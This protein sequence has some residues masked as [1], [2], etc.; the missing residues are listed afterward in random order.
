MFV[1]AWI[2]AMAMGGKKI[3]RLTALNVLEKVARSRRK[4]LSEK[5]QTKPINATFR[6]VKSN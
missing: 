6:A 5:Y 4:M 3:R 2:R 1:L